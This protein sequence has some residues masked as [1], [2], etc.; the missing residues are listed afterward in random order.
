M[1]TEV[2]IANSALIK[3]SCERIISL[4]DDLVRAR[5]AKEQ[6]PKL[7]DFVLEAFPWTFAQKRAALAQDSDT[8]AWGYTYQYPLPSDYYRITETDGTFE[9]VI[10]GRMLLT[11][12]SSVN[13]KYTAIQSDPGKFTPTFAEAVSTALAADLAYPLVQSSELA[14][15]LQKQYIY[16]ISQAKSSNSQGRGSP[17][18]PE[19]SDFINSRF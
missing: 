4:D 19:V 6:Y 13:I 15:R 18:D 12:E 10:E 11:D 5:L 1:I 2:S 17:R 7:R 3:I 9:H 8:P 14:D 16:M